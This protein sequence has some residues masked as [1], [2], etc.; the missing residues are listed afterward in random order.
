MQGDNLTGC[1]EVFPYFLYSADTFICLYYHEKK[2]WH[3]CNF[4]QRKWLAPE[5]VFEDIK[6]LKEI[7]F[8]TIS[9]QL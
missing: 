8:M 3:F 9:E 1:P 2:Y 6:K 7:D 4:A 5:Q